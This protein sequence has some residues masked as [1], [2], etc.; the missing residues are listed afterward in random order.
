MTIRGLHAPV[1]Q[2]DRVPGYEP[3]GR[4][5]ES[6]RAR[7]IKSPALRGAFLFGAPGRVRTSDHHKDGSTSGEA[8]QDARVRPEGV[9][10]EGLNPSFRARQIKKCPALRGA[11]YLARPEGFEPPTITRR[12]DQ[13]RSRASSLARRGAE[14]ILPGAPNKKRPRLQSG[15]F[16]FGAPKS[17]PS[18]RLGLPASPGT[19]EVA[20]PQRSF[21]CKTPQLP[22]LAKATPADSSVKRMGVI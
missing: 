5:F 22:H 18:S 20:N 14:A 9:K 15:A 19:A 12:F 8:A 10:A 6:F 2:L 16:L 4:R 17:P 3:G 7:Q 1:A 21:G 11:F 13:R